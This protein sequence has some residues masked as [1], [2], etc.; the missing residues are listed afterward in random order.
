MKATSTLIISTVFFSLFFLFS[1]H[2]SAQGTKSGMKSN[3]LNPTNSTEKVT[4]QLQPTDLI[5]PISVKLNCLDDIMQVADPG[6]CGAIV[7]YPMPT[8][9]G[10]VLTI[11][12]Q[13]SGTFFSVGETYV[14][15]LLPVITGIR[16][17]VQC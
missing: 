11:V 4:K 7:E 15:L 6:L 12:G 13:M 3:S 5:N 17:R 10:G 1:Q 9:E 8:Y 16:F 14:F 2:V